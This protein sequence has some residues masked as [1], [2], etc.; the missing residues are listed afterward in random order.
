MS[1]YIIQSSL[2]TITDQ[3]CKLTKNVVTPIYFY[4]LCFIQVQEVTFPVYDS[5]LLVMILSSSQKKAKH[6][7][8]FLLP[9]KS[10]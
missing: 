2:I 7:F 10:V 8:C 5:T 4:N 6:N 9:F 1:K 3:T